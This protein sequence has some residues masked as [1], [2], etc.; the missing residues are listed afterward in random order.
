MAPDRSV[1]MRAGWVLT[2]D[3]AGTVYAPGEVGFVNG[4]LTY[5]GPPRPTATADRVIDLGIGAIAPGL[6]NGHTHAAMS[7]MR[8]LADD[9]PLMPWL[10]EHVWPVEAHMTPED[11]YL[12]TVLAGV[13]MA[14][15]GIVG[16]LDMYGMA[17]Q[18]AR[19]ARTVGLRAAVAYGFLGD[20][21]DAQPKLERA[22]DLCR[23]LRD[24]ADGL[25]EGWLGP[26]APYTCAPALLERVA[27]AQADEGWRV[28]IHLAESVDEDR[29]IR[30]RYGLSPV[31]LVERVGLLGPR[32]AVAHA[33]HLD[34]R[35]IERLARSGAGAVHCPV[36]NQKLGNGV[37]PI[38]E[39]KAAGVPVGLG[40]DGPA[41]TNTLNLFQEM[42]LA[43]W[44]QKARHSD[45]AAF[46][47]GDALAMATRET[48]RVLGWASGVLAA[49][50]PADLVAVRWWQAHTQP[51]LDPVSTFVY[52]TTPGDV[53][54]T[55]VGGRL[56]LDD[57]VVTT[58]DE[59]AVLREARDRAVA[60]LARAGRR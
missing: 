33:V 16:F 32:T 12:G 22:L 18:V 4:V 25:V 58:V 11:V 48:A 10:R 36:S 24:E 15:A 49:G 26:H 53:R 39:L 20:W 45:P 6:L 59:E 50:R 5:V 23:A 57:G 29:E 35:D 28:H 30:A 8:G 54:Y 60:L 37:A 17:D 51:V 31:A 52:A 47:A 44:L 56:V 1:I 38:L 46:R 27:A 40:T 2:G 43:A 42:R 3:A 7:L 55:V 41:S 19:A 9:W 13:E 14:R 21:P 34:A